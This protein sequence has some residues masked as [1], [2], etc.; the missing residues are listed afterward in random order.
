M[1]ERRTGAEAGAY[2]GAHFQPL[3][4]FSHLLPV[5]ESGSARLVD[6]AQP[7]QRHPLMGGGMD[8]QEKKLPL[9]A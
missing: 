1:K 5:A 6:V 8:G 3:G 4:Q 2:H 9:R 7:F